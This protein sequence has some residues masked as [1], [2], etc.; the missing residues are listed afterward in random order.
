MEGSLA[1][2]QFLKKSSGSA[3]HC[4]IPIKCEATATPRENGGG[5]PRPERQGLTG[6]AHLKRHDG[7]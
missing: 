7:D 6:T 1:R 5:Y 2:S 4:P 3:I